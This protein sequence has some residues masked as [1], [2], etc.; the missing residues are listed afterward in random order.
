MVNNYYE[1]WAEIYRNL[2]ARVEPFMIKDDKGVEVEDQSR[3]NFCL[4]DHFVMLR[5][6]KARLTRNPPTLRLR[7]SNQEQANKTALHLMYQWDKAESQRSFRKIVLNAKAFGIG[8]GKSYYDKVVVTREFRRLT[9]KLDRE[10]LMRLQGAPDEEVQQAVDQL[11]SNLSDSELSQATAKHGNQVTVPTDVTKYEGAKLDYVF[12]GDLN[13]EPGFRSLNESG[14]QIENQIRDEQWLDYWT[15]QVSIDPETGE[16]SP[17]IEKKKADEL[18]EMCGDRQY[19]DEK[20]ISLRRMMR[21]AVEI[22][23]PRTAGKPPKNPRKRFM[24]DERHSIVNGRLLIEFVGEESV[25]LGKLWYPWNTYGKSV[26]TDMVLIPDMIEGIGDSTLRISR[27]LM[28]LRNARANQT[29]DFINNKLL[30]LLKMLSNA[31]ITNENLI[32]TAYARV[33]KVK[34]MGD[35]EFQQEPPFPAE[36][37]QDTAT[38]VREMQ[39][40]EPA[41]ND[42][43]PG[44]EEIPQ[45]GKLA[46]TAILQKQGADAVLADELNELGQFIRDTMEIHLYLNQQAMEDGVDLDPTALPRAK[47]IVE[48][49]SLGTQGANPRTIRIDPMD[50]QEEFEIIPEEGSTL[51]QDDEYRTGRL[52]QG[53]QLALSAPQVFNVRTFA[54]AYLQSVPGISP[55]E[56]LAEPQP[57]PPPQPRISFN[58]AAKFEE[59]SGDVQ[60]AIL[61]EAGLPTEGT[62]A[63][64]GIQHT[65]DVVEHIGRA[66]NAAAELESPAQPTPDAGEGKTPTPAGMKGMKGG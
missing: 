17:V 33:V 12:C 54:K 37:W 63:L 41:M 9:A 49:L 53:L 29:T 21:E 59:L 47:T 43:Q 20:D 64:A 55:E 30:P 26:Y 8:Y 1:E 42:F 57:P 22:A 38:Y 44:T 6:G 28:Q 61:G 5:H 18:L 40:V 48:A 14:Y 23:D 62:T 19:I 31:N 52:M 11:G 34:N 46:T 7:G 60:A 3:S 65:A 58:I 16:E 2:K 24:L 32:R 56:G 36:A 45:A 13:L 27:F 4:P 35:M 50:I 66:A 10:S 25:Y 15:R 51:A 39:Q